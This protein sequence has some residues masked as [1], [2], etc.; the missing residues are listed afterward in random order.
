MTITEIAKKAGTSRGTV[1]RVINGRGKVRPELEAKIRQ[2]IKEEN[3]RPNRLARALIN[4]RRRIHIGVVIHSIGNPFFH[5]VLKGINQRM[6]WLEPYGAIK[7]IIE[8]RGYHPEEQIKA[9]YQLLEQGIDGLLIMPLDTPEIRKLLNSL[10]IP[11]VT[12]NLDLAIENKIA[13]V[14]CDYYNSGALSGDLASLLLRQGGKVAAVI[15]SFEIAGHLQRFRGF[16]DS[17]KNF[18]D[19][20]IIAVLENQDDEEKSYTAVRK[21]LQ[22]QSPD[23]IYFG[24]AGIAGGIQAV[25][26]SKKPV[27]MITV[28][29]TTLVRKY[30]EEGVISATITQQP[31]LQ[32]NISIKILFDYIADN[33]IPKERYCYTENQVLLKHSKTSKSHDLYSVMQATI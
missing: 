7:T 17:L 12:F 19:I 24:A 16:S 4:S 30:L 26:D 21:L 3:Y 14:G 11:V 2:I 29:E 9:V 18:P 27:H 15:G 32:G 33:I 5:D 1:D 25:L 31:F 23:L 20:E 8:L 10:T 13:F 6:E 22:K 28:D